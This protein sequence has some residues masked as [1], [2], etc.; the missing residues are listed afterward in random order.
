LVKDLAGIFRTRIE[1]RQIGL[2]DESKILGGVGIC[3]KPFCC[4]T[5][6]FEFQ[7]VSIKM[8]KEQGKSLNP[9]KISGTCGRLMCCLKYEQEVYETLGKNIPKNGTPV[10]T[11]DGNGVVVDSSVLGQTVKVRMGDGADAVL[12]HYNV[13]EVEFGKRGERL[14]PRQLSQKQEAAPEKEAKE[15]E[16]PAKPAQQRRRGNRRRGGRKNKGNSP[17]PK[18]T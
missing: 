1:L 8:A 10:A 13:A 14:P 2:R 9:T 6:L 4:S 5:F 18:N 17:T 7:P 12:R 11:Q 16:D 15:K 3:G